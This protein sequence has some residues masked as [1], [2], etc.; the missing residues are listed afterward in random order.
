MKKT[1]KRRAATAWD[2]N[3]SQTGRIEECGRSHGL[4][5]HVRGRGPS[6][7]RSQSASDLRSENEPKDGVLPP[8]EPGTHLPDVMGAL[9]PVGPQ[10]IKNNISR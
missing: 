1:T 5:P 4:R 10:P 7:G 6:V 8:N 9:R 2:E 3:T